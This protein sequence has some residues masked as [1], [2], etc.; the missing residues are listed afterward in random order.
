VIGDMILYS[1][2]I[3]GMFFYIQTHNELDNLCI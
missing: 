2:G 1:E 3:I